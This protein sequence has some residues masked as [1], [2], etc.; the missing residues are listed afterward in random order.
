MVKKRIK[1]GKSFEQLKEKLQRMSTGL[2]GEVTSEHGEE[3]G[4]IMTAGR[5]YSLHPFQKGKDYLS[6]HVI[7]PSQSPITGLRKKGPATG[8]DIY[9]AT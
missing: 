3:W 6:K 9:H 8:T 5:F 7:K 2:T 1:P 4:P